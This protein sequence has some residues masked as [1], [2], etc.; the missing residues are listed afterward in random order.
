MPLET[1][2]RLGHYEVEGALGEGGMGAVY[3]ARDT[4]LG[5]AVAIKVL[6]PEAAGDPDL[7]QRLERE[8]RVISRLSHPNICAL[9]DVGREDDVDF[10]VMEYLEGETLAERLQKGPLPLSEALAIG[11]DVAAALDAAHQSGLVH[12]DLKPGNVMLTRHGAKLLDFGLAKAFLADFGAAGEDV[13]TLVAPDGSGGDTAGPTAI[14]PV[15]AEGMIVGTLHYMAPEQ[16]EGQTVDARADLF[17]FGCI[18][19]EMVTGL[20][21]FGGDSRAGVMAAVLHHQPPPLRQLSPASPPALERLVAVCL[22][23]DPEERWRT[24]H[25]L[26]LQLGWIRDESSAWRRAAPTRTAPEAPRGR[27]TAR[28]AALVAAGVAAGALAVLLAGLLRSSLGPPEGT[29]TGPSAS[30]PVLRFQVPL[31]EDTTVFFSDIR[32]PVAVSPDGARLALVAVEDGVPRLYVR[33]LDGLETRRLEGTEGVFSAVFSPDGRSL[34]FNVNDNRLLRVAVEGGPARDLG[35]RPSGVG[36]AA[37]TTGDV[38][39]FPTLRGLER[40]P[41]AG[42]EPEPIVLAGAPEPSAELLY[43]THGPAYLPSQIPGTSRILYKANRPD[44]GELRATSL[45]PGEADKEWTVPGIRSQGRIVRPGILVYAEGQSLYGRRIDL[46]NLALRGEPAVLADHVHHFHASGLVSFAVSEEVLIY[47]GGRDVE[48]LIWVDR[49]GREEEEVGEP[50]DYGGARLSPRGDRLA[51]VVAEEIEATDVWVFDLERGVPSRFT[52]SGS[53]KSD[54]VWAGEERLIFTSRVERTP[55]IW[56]RRLGDPEEERLLPPDAV[57]FA[58]D[59]SPDG[60]SLLFNRTDNQGDIFLLELGGQGEVVPFLAT[61]HGEWGGRFSPDGRWIALRSGE[62]GRPEIYL[63]RVDRPAVR[64]RVS[65]AGGTEPRFRGDG[66]E[67]FYRSLDDRVM[68]VDLVLGD[69]PEIGAPGPLF[70]LGGR[71]FGDVAP[72]G[73]RFLLVRVDEDSARAPFTVVVGWQ[74]LVPE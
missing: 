38:L 44:G 7:I 34:L 48:R 61:D 45:D 62:T 31:P 30:P 24:A 22:E 59:V 66:R 52:S 36:S 23:K 33:E 16:L 54:P 51:V 71:R 1:G 5:R 25:D 49:E 3:L 68:A 26:A 27:R 60:R 35:V 50:A 13:P 64:H 67:L 15:T 19:Y 65:L 17:A 6:R 2:H 9:Y 56:L 8:A 28:A 53:R 14:M 46:E 4:R 43:K 73:G 57:R 37:W 10:L 42:G 40:L 29:G 32:S 55:N 70:P 63:A 58:A 21:P 18:L 69:E 72:D 11:L 39:V 12:R 20:R 41:A 47:R 74:A